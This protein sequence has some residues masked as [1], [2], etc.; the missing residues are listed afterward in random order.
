MALQLR[1][2]YPGQCHGVARVNHDDCSCARVVC[3]AKNLCSRRVRK[4]CAIKPQHVLA[5]IEVRDCVL[6]EARIKHTNVSLP[7]P[8]VRVSLLPACSCLYRA[9]WTT[10]ES[11]TTSQAGFLLLI[12]S[13]GRTAPDRENHR[14]H[15][16]PPP[17]REKGAFLAEALRAPSS[18]AA[19][20]RTRLSGQWHL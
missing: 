20:S 6:A 16:H 7:P 2:R 14:P 8:P 15:T 3:S 9:L 10:G 18:R 4:Q 5:D 12:Q 17:M 13:G 19:A 11:R 1:D